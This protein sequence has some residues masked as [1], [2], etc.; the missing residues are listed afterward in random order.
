MSDLRERARRERIRILLRTRNDYLPS[1]RAKATPFT[2]AGPAP[3]RKRKC[4][5]C[6]GTGK[7]RLRQQCP[8][9]AG[10]Q[11]IEVDSYVGRV[12][13]SDARKP[14]PMSAERREAEIQRL[15][16]SLTLAAGNVDPEEK[17]AWERA[18]ESRDRNGS[19]VE[20]ERALESLTPLDR[21]F[22]AWVYDSGLNV[23]VSR[24][25][26]IREAKIVGLLSERMPSRIRLPRH[27][28][29]ELMDDK[30]RRVKEMRRC[31]LTLPEIS[32]RV[33]LSERTLEKFA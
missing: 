7:T 21:D 28:H 23:E 25:S 13:S 14:E 18:R 26:Q 6:G 32:D 5:A 12:T 16:S 9:C 29:E 3:G 17:Y 33:L 8:A 30:R 24:A 22:I 11:T 20:L 31:G 19:Y 4:P 15:Q 1:L 2:V 27:L 10:K